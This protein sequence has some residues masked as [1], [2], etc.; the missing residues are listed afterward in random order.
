MADSGTGGP[1]VGAADHAT[2]TASPSA[3]SEAAPSFSAPPE[4]SH[5][6]Y[7]QARLTSWLV[8]TSIEFGVHLANGTAGDFL[9]VLRYLDALYVAAMEREARRAHRA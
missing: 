6:R 3:G 1:G 9:A 4:P 8:T 5:S 7:F 2:Q